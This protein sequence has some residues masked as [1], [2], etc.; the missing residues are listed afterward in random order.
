MRIKYNNAHKVKNGDGY[1]SSVGWKFSNFLHGHHQ[2]QE[3][4]EAPGSWTT[5]LRSER[6]GAAA[7]CAWLEGHSCLRALLLPAH[8]GTPNGSPDWD[9]DTNGS[10]VREHEGPQPGPQL[11]PP[12][13]RPRVLEP[14][15]WSTVLQRCQ[16][17]PALCNLRHL[18][19]C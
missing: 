13:S 19:S 9:G 3:E 15:C 14:G 10:L 11:L 4:T 7:R 2:Y 12:C 8:T 18:G 5:V 17:S 6:E 1:M 16:L